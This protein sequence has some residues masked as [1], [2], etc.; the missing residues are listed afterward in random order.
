[1]ETPFSAREQ[2]RLG[3]AFFVQISTLN[4]AITFL[5]FSRN[6]FKP[7][8]FH[9]RRIR[10]FPC[11]CANILEKGWGFPRKLFEVGVM[12]FP[13]DT[14][15]LRQPSCFRGPILFRNVGNP[16]G[17]R[18]SGLLFFGYFLFAEA[19]ESDLLPGNPRLGRKIK[20]AGK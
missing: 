16:E 2:G 14:S 19:K 7:T 9:N 18:H 11:C 5:F 12:T 6:L 4:R 3:F 10:E 20:V 1:M 8:F 17:A 13:L 15:R